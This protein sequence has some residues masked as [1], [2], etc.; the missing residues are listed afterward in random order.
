MGPVLLGL[1]LAVLLVIAVVR[2]LRRSGLDGPE[3]LLALASA[4]LPPE[5]VEWATAMRA[6][7]QALQGKAERWRFASGCARVAMFAP[8][9]SRIDALSLAL[10]AAIVA[11]LGGTAFI[12]AAYPLEGYQTVWDGRRPV[13]LAV[14]ALFLGGYL[15]V[16]LRPPLMLSALPVSR[17]TGL[18]A[19][20]LFGLTFL[21]A[22]Y[23][24][25]GARILALILGPVVILTSAATIAATRA[26]NARAGVMAGIWG[27]LT[28]GVVAFTANLVPSLGKAAVIGSDLGSSTSA[29]LMFPLW[30]LVLGIAGGSL[31]RSVQAFTDGYAGR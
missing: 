20:V 15:W 6:E 17:R 31:A 24:G 19:G 7:L 18:A 14:L 23:G 1:P 8:R 3:R 21:L 30:G 22:G 9:S 13:L 16:A 28:A 5:R 4:G 26:R 29:L 11:C 27:G 10:V 12:L 2:L 25:E